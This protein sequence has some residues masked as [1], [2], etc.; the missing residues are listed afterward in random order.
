MSKL[1]LLL[2]SLFVVAQ[3]NAQ[4]IYQ[5]PDK[6]NPLQLNDSIPHFSLLNANNEQVD[7][8]AILNE[9]S[10]VLIFYRAGWCPF[11]NVHLAEIQSVEDKI[12]KLGYQ[13]IAI[14]TDKPEKLQETSLKNSLKYTLLSDPTCEVAA[15]FGVAFWAGENWQLPVPALFV[16]NKKG[17]VKFEHTDP[18]YKQRIAAST[19]LDALKTI[20]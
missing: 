8:N 3:L 1:F 14:S 17:I 7:F 18:N 12:L 15:K 20:K 19:L 9:K 10:V 11:C 4:Q 16:I 13:I 5:S 2:S 6:I